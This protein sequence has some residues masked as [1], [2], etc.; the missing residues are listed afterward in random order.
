MEIT[1]LAL[2]LGFYILRYAA[3]NLEASEYLMAL[4]S[5]CWIFG[6]FG[7]GYTYLNKPSYILGY[8]SQAAYPVYIIHMFVMY[9]GAYLILRIP[10]IPYGNF[11][12]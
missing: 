7:L 1:Y 10:F 5:N 2:A 11:L 3:F 8:L 12:G 9:L 4:E 6:V